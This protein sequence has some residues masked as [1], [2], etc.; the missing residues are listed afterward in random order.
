MSLPEP[1]LFHY[2]QF[3]FGRRGVAVL[4][5]GYVFEPVY[6]LRAT[7]RLFIREH[8]EHSSTGARNQPAFASFLTCARHCALRISACILQNLITICVRVDRPATLAERAASRMLV[9]T[10]QKNM[11]DSEFGLLRN[12]HGARP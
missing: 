6:C 12:I 8:M 5:W 3:M 1:E 10:G 7:D 4:T 11:V 9:S 2:D